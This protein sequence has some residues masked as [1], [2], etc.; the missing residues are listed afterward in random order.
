[1]YTSTL[2]QGMYA[3]AKK[4]KPKSI[5]ILSAKYG[6]LQPRDIIEPY[7]KTLNNMGEQE[8]KRWAENVLSELKI[9]TNIEEDH[10]IFLAGTSYRKY[11]LPHLKHFSI[12]MQGLPF[13]KQLQWLK[14][15]TT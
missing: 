7:E 2:F 5:F 11:I 6:L 12:P 14:E 10:F 15:H 9:H 3:Y 4:Q 8:R 13:G 1:M